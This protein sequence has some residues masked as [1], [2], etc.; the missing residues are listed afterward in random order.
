MSSWRALSASQSERCTCSSARA[1]L[2]GG[3]AEPLFELLHR[4]GEV[5][6]LAAQ[7]AQMLRRARCRGFDGALVARDALLHRTNFIH[8]DAQLADQAPDRVVLQAHGARQARNF[9]RE[10]AHLPAQPAILFRLRLARHGDEPLAEL[11]EFAAQPRH[12]FTGGEHFARAGVIGFVA[13]N[14][15]VELQH[16]AGGDRAGGDLFTET[17][18]LV[19]D[20]GATRKNPARSGLAAFDAARDADFAFAVEQ[21]YGAHFA[22]VETDRIVRL[23]ETVGFEDL[24]IRV[25][26]GVRI[27]IALMQKG[28]IERKLIDVAG[29]QI[30]DFFEEHENRHPC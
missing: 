1:Q 15:V 30:Y 8:G 3:C 28:R 5:A 9:H 21:R 13:G 19:N 27:G 11:L 4:E 10:P 17:N 18:H 23:I 24:G 12:L 6:L 14:R 22:Q 7:F 16:I 2:G 20:D 26:I 29:K 25:R